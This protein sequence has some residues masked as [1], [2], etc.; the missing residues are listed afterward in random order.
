M[1]EF[2]VRLK[3]LAS[4]C[5]FGAFLSQAQRHLPSMRELTYS[6]AHD[7]CIADEMAGKANIGHMGDSA[8]SNAEKVQQVY[9]RRNVE[10]N[11]KRADKCKSCGSMQHGLNRADS[12][13]P[14]A[15]TA[16]RKV[17]FAVC[18]KGRLK[19]DQVVKRSQK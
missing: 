17:V 16:R 13:M 5:S 19:E 3:K 7:K 9:S 11:S 4:T 10:Q 14:H 15:I 2:V 18:H 8:N 12:K 6:M 1:S